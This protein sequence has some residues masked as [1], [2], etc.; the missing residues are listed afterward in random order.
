M[1]EISRRGVPAGLVERGL[2][3]PGSVRPFAGVVVF[4]MHELAEWVGNWA[5]RPVTVTDV[6]CATCGKAG[7]RLVAKGEPVSEETVYCATCR[8][9]EGE[10]EASSP[11]P[12]TPLVVVPDPPADKPLRRRS[13]A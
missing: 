9:E 8:P 3:R 6:A 12:G 11:A 13:L 10:V 7:V 2:I 5:P 1:D 4:N